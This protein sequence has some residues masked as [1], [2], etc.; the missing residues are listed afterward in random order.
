[1]TTSALLSLS[2]VI[3]TSLLNKVAVVAVVLVGEENLVSPP[4]APLLGALP[5]SDESVFDNVSA[6]P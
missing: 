4:A 5:V 1:M 2:A 6:S 3:F